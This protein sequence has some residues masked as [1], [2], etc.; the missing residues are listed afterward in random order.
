VETVER[1]TLAVVQTPQAFSAGILRRALASSD[2]DFSD[3]SG[4]VEAAGGRV[5]VVD[6]DPR[7][8]KV[9]TRSDLAVIERLLAE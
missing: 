7:L 2:A 9:T 6:G 1:A 4:F 5:R 8:L 3:C